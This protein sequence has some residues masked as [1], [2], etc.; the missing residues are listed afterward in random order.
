MTR[1]LF[2]GD[3][4]LDVLPA[5]SSNDVIDSRLRHAEVAGEFAQECAC[6][7]PLTDRTDGGDGQS[8]LRMSLASV[9][10]VTA[11]A[12]AVGSVVRTCA[13]VEVAWSY[14]DAV[15]AV[16]QDPE[17]VGDRAVVEFPRV[18][19]RHEPPL[20][21]SW[22]VRQPS[23]ASA[24]SRALP[25]PTTVA[26]RDFGPETDL[27]AGQLLGASRTAASAIHPATLGTAGLGEAN[28]AALTGI[29][30]VAHEEI[31]P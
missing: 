1:V 28:A 3:D 26:L 25:L 30:P 27:Q 13:H 16:V 17:P 10:P 14:T 21:A 29:G 15:I 11:A 22:S 20:N 5:A 31:L 7:A 12:I 18:S 8:V 19:V 4:L 9:S 2:W 24:G 23:V 6:G